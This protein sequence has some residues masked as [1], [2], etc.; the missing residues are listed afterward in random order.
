MSPR[1]R[2][3]WSRD[4]EW[5]L[6]RGLHLRNWVNGSDSS[7][8]SWQLRYML[9]PASH[10]ALVQPGCFLGS[11]WAERMPAG[12]SANVLGT[13]LSAQVCCVVFVRASPEHLEDESDCHPRFAAPVWPPDPMHNPDHHLCLRGYF[14]PEPEACSRSQSF[15]MSC[16][17]DHLDN[18]LLLTRRRLE[19]ALFCCKFTPTPSQVITDDDLLLISNSGYDHLLAGRKGCS[20]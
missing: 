14:S 15:A 20:A 12:S 6:G 16:L 18:V 2:G 17:K 19:I 5:D 4:N 7:L 10:R 3:A 8:Q 1:M 11:F 13:D 9:A